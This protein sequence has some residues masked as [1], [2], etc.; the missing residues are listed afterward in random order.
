MRHDEPKIYIQRVASS[1]YVG[2]HDD[3]VSS[4]AEA[5][6]FN[7]CLIALDFCMAR[8]LSRVQIRACFADHRPDVVWPVTKVHG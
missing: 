7:S 8:R 6:D 1:H 2:V 4:V 3:W 5:R